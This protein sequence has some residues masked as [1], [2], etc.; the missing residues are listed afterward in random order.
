MGSFVVDFY[1]ASIRLA[2]EIDG[3]SHQNPGASFYDQTRQSMIEALGI[4]V[5]RF[6]EREAVQ[7]PQVIADQ[8]RAIAEKQSSLLT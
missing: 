1:C 4:T 3:A 5:I 6:S 2:I 8:I 7:S